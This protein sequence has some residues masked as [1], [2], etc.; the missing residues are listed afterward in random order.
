MGLGRRQ[1]R[2]L[3]GSTG[4]IGPDGLGGYG[5][6][7]PGTANLAFNGGFL[8]QYGSGQAN[9]WVYRG[10][11]RVP[12][13]LRATLLISGLLAQSP[14]D[15]YKPQGNDVPE[16]ITPRPPL[17]EQMS[18]PDPRVT[19]LRSAMI[20]RIHDGNAIF[21]VA[22]RN[23]LGEPT[24]VWPVPASWV[25]VRRINTNNH[26]TSML[27][28]GSIEYQVGSSTFSSDDVIH[29]K[30]PCAPGALRGAGVL[31]LA[32]EGTIETA[33]EQEREA[34]KMS[35]HGVPSGILKFLTDTPSGTHDGQQLPM[36]QRMQDAADQW[37][38]ARDHNG[39]A[40]MNSAVDFTPLAWKPDDMQMVQARQFTLLQIANIMGVPPK[41]V[42]A[43]TGDSLTYATSETG[44]KELL[45]DT[46]GIYFEEFDQTFSLA[47]PN[48]RIN[49][50]FDRDAF[51]RSDLLQRYQAYQIGIDTGLLLK[52]EARAKE[53]LPPVDGIDDIGPTGSVAKQLNKGLPITEEGL[54]QIT[55]GDLGGVPGTGKPPALPPAQPAVPIQALAQ[56]LPVT[57]TRAS[58]LEI[59]PGTSLWIYWTVGK[60]TARWMEKPHPWTALRDA[61]ISEGV[62]PRQAVGLATNIMQATPAGKAL[63]AAHHQGGGH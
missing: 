61:L 20:D 40:V 48:R 8:G 3:P 43:Q 44:G 38:A 22:S 55:V 41:F 13:I 10:A 42:G 14:W 25:G 54:K 39:V 6:L 52:S 46:M 18:P 9:L 29:V 28:V 31:E 50:Q 51:T 33:H 24:A 27:P 59:S 53:F 58:E 5:P 32:L 26:Y 1:Y 4:M 63:F 2:G 62:S 16:K 35:R 23:A 57:G 45:R 11:L 60:G 7:L 19:S 17:L 36:R 56:R 37:L 34:Q 49:V 30:G 12:G 15:A 47:F 21:V